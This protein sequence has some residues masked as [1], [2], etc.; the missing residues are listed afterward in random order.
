LGESFTKLEGELLVK[1]RLLLVALVVCHSS[2]ALA[3]GGSL[4]SRFGIGEIRT[5][6]TAQS[7]GMGFAGA[8]IPDPFYI[9]RINPAMLT[10]VD[11]ARVSGD[12][13]YIGYLATT[14]QASGYQVVAG[15]EGASLAIPIWNARVVLSTGLLPYSRINYKQTQQG[16][17][18]AQ[19]SSDTV[20]YTFSYRGLGGLNSAPVAVGVVPVKD[21]E[22]WGVLRLGSAINFIFG[23]ST[24]GSEHQFAAF[25]LVDS[26]IEFEDRLAGTSLTLG[27]AYSTRQGIF[28]AADQFTLGV[29]WTTG[30]TLKGTRQA[31]LINNLG[32][33][34]FQTRDTLW[35]LD[36]EAK[37]PSSIT[38]STAYTANSSLTIAAD[39][40]V[41]E[42]ADIRY[43]G[44]QSEIQ[45]NAL[46]LALGAEIIPS[47]EARANVFLRSAYRLG[48]YYHRTNIQIAGTGIDELGITF[49]MGIPLSAE[50]SR[51]DIYLHYALRGTKE[52][53]LIQE[54]IFRI[55]AAL[56]I[57][58]K[59]F[60]Q[61][62]IE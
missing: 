38:I 8:A 42:W 32:S 60:L 36:G 55:G 9:N 62:K 12:F 45:R 44:A 58:E 17:F 46:R 6:A 23:A 28:A 49:G 26:A 56:N 15:W 2:V 51:L 4:Y 19:S 31:I 40:T 34:Q 7:A 16:R 37:L 35:V 1:T 47:S 39:L 53:N 14:A 3:Q 24:Q 25:E 10:A 50:S 27:A 33:S 13:S 41:Q 48:A 20:R 5:Q 57:G 22:K 18:V 52:S 59:W 21:E 54:N 30:T 29:S 11:Q 43:F 61:R